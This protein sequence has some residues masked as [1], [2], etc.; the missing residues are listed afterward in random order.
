MSSTEVEKYSSGFIFSQQSELD[1][2][3]NPENYTDDVQTARRINQ[4]NI[5][6][7][8]KAA[9]EPLKSHSR[10]TSKKRIA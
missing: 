10:E 4:Q 5:S 3:E 8:Q 9:S 1:S 2:L 6:T 7:Y